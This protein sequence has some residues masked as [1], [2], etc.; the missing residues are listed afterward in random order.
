MGYDQYVSL[1]V[2]G[3]KAPIELLAKILNNWL[4]EPKVSK[5]PDSSNYSLEI[6][7]DWS[8]RIYEAEGILIINREDVKELSWIPHAKPTED[9]GDRQL[10][11][12]IVEFAKENA[13]N[14]DLDYTGEEQGDAEIIDT[15]VTPNGVKVT[16]RR[17]EYIETDFS[18]DRMRI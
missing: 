5:L 16:Y 10:Y 4:T 15:E 7:G 6:E 17:M 13:L 2:V 14:M 1:T 9:E 3:T 12:D 11:F 8:R 18:I